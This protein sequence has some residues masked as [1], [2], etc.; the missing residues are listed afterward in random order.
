MI[1]EHNFLHDNRKLKIK[2]NF[3]AEWAFKLSTFSHKCFKNMYQTYKM[4]V[5]LGVSYFGSNKLIMYKVICSNIG[6]TLM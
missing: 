4:A 6:N 2:M 1:N 5:F 3:W